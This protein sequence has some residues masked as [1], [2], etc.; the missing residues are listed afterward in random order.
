M[1]NI[2]DAKPRYAD[3]GAADG[4]SAGTVKAVKNVGDTTRVTF[5]STKSQYMGTSCVDSKRIVTWDA[6]TRRSTIVRARTPGWSRSTARR[7]R[8]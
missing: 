5:V 6:T 7:P 2:A 8:C 3:I 4:H 1:R